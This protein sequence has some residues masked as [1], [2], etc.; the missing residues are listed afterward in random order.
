MFSN[1]TTQAHTTF[2]SPVIKEE[3][4]C[5][6]M[7]VEMHT[8]VGDERANSVLFKQLLTFRDRL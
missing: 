5:V 1:L 6:C 3:L 7:C 8:C 2:T 4:V